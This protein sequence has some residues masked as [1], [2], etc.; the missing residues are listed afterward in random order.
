M[1]V[2][3]SR[4]K[5]VLLSSTL[6]SSLNTIIFSV[7]NPSKYDLGYYCHQHNLHCFNIP[8]SHPVKNNKKTQTKKP[9][10]NKQINQPLLK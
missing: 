4:L 10:R 9:P 8:R 1:H 3:Q 5:H 7:N 2:Y 6:Q